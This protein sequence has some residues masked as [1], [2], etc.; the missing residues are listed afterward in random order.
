MSV[1]VPDPTYDAI[2]EDIDNCVHALLD[3]KYRNRICS[4]HRLVYGFP[5]ELCQ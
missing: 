2:Y 4:Y 3:S 5:P 1:G